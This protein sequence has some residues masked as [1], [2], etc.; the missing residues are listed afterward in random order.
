MNT[1]EEIIDKETKEL[2]EW[3]GNF[4]YDMNKAIMPDSTPHPTIKKAI[5]TA[6]MKM[7]NEAR[8]DAERKQLDKILHI[9]E[10]TENRVN[11][12][13]NDVN[14]FNDAVDSANKNYKRG[15]FDGINNA[16]TK[17]KELIEWKHF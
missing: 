6:C 5:R 10:D 9:L 17:I 2:F 4:N 11:P 15:F 8:A 3:I 1:N 7:L 13:F 12:F 16:K 14:I